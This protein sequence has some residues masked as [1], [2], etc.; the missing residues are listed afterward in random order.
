MTSSK[1]PIQPGTRPCDLARDRLARIYRE[2]QSVERRIRSLREDID[3][4]NRHRHDRNA[5]MEH[6]WQLTVRDELAQISLLEARRATLLQEEQT[7][8]AEYRRHCGV[9]S[10]PRPTSP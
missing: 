7:A 10:P 9:E 3:E 1:R 5:T 6:E 4:G 2:L 8:R